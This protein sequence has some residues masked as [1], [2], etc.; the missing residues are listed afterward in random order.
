MKKTTK[1]ALMILVAVVTGIMGQQFVHG[2]DVNIG[3]GLV[4]NTDQV[5]FIII[6]G[7]VAGLTRSF[8]GYEK[9]PNDFDG[10]LFAKTTIQMVLISIPAA[11]AY[12]LALPELNAVGYV[13]AFFTIAGMS[14]YLRAGQRKTIPSNAT[15][16][17]ISRILDERG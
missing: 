16:D 13:F 2:E 8:L 10:L 7:G 15:E 4:L 11:L 5:I 3:G 17:E 12:V 1:V 9:S 6:I 14:D